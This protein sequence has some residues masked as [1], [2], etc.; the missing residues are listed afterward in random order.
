M[1]GF[2]SDI[3]AKIGVTLSS[4]LSA[5]GVGGSSASAVCQTTC[6]T[7]SALPF[8]LGFTLSA[9]PLAFIE[10]YQLPLWW[11]SFIVFCVLLILFIK[12]ILHSRIDRAFLFLNAGLLL[13]GFPYFSEGLP[14]L[15][16]VGLVIVILGIYLFI[17]AKRFIIQWT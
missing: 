5:L 12:K 1:I 3:K 2:I 9:T 6:S 10:D 13:I 8:F 7:G 16:W 15:P 14:F 17:S 11:I 4:L